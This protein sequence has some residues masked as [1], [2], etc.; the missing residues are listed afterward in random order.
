MDKAQKRPSEASTPERDDIVASDV[1]IRF[2]STGKPF[3]SSDAMFGFGS[4]DRTHPDFPHEKRWTVVADEGV[5][6]RASTDFGDKAAGQGPSV[7]TQFNTNSCDLIIANDKKPLWSDLSDFS[8]CFAQAQRLV[9]PTSTS[10]SRPRS[11]IPPCTCTSL[12]T[13]QVEL[14]SFGEKQPPHNPTKQCHLS[15]VSILRLKLLLE[16]M[17]VF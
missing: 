16:I 2:L 13:V 15:T 3:I 14:H 7:G 9:I 8:L 10:S 12:S 1:R 6:W 17:A 11:E 4:S 5:A